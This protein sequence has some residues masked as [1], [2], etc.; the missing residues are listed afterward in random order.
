MNGYGSQRR[1]TA[2]TLSAIQSTTMIV[3]TARKRPVPRNRAIP[4]ANRPTASGLSRRKLP[5]ERA[6]PRG[7]SRRRLSA[8]ASPLA[9]VLGQQV[10]EHV[11]DAHRADQPA[12]LVDHGRSD[13][14]V[15]REVAGDLAQRRL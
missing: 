1:S 5:N 7:M 3:W 12:L 2:A 10:V 8:T 15:G 11:V 13:Q 6:R 4:S 9:P 14:V